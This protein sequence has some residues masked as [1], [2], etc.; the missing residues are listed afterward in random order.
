MKTD[1]SSVGSVDPVG[2]ETS[3]APGRSSLPID[4]ATPLQSERGRSEHESCQPDLHQALS[5][6]AALIPIASR[7]S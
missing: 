7:I 4:R 2:N 5:V 3:V 1:R 6:T